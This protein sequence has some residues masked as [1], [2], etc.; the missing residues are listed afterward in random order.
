MGRFH[1]GVASMALR[2]GVPVVPVAIMGSYQMKRGQVAAVIGKPIPV[3]KAKP[4][5]EAIAEL[6]DKV[7]VALE[8]LMADYRAAHPDFK[9]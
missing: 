5:P 6:N 8:G 7:R 4:T 1:D 2:T 3:A 9:R